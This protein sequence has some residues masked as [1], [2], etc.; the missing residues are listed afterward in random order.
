MTMPAWAFQVAASS[1]LLV[2]LGLLV[3]SV[4]TPRR[5]PGGMPHRENIAL[6]AFGV[7]FALNLF[8]KA[9]RPMDIDVYVETGGLTAL[10][11]LL[12]IRS[13][14]ARRAEIAL[15]PVETSAAAPARRGA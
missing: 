5:Q 12:A 13:F 4:M 15:E 6:C 14:R 10:L 9:P 3:L 7:M 1:Q 11:C 2:M 8:L